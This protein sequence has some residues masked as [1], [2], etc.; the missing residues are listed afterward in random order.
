[1]TPELL[2]LRG[3]ACYRDETAIDF[4]GLDAPLFAIAGP[5]GS[6]K[7]V[8]LDAITFALYGQTARLGARGV[9]E[10][11]VSPGASTMTVQ[12][13]FST[14]GDRYRITRAVTVRASGA[15][16]EVRIEAEG[17]PGVWA[18]HAA[19]EKIR[20]AN[21]LLESIV[22]LDYDGFTR[23][24]LLPQGAFDEFLRGD[25]AK[26]RS[27]LTSL[28]NLDRLT[29]MQQEARRVATAAADRA[30]S[31]EARLTED[32]G[33]ATPEGVDRAREAHD[34]AVAVAA[35]ATAEAE[36][37]TAESARL[38]RLH[39]AHAQ[40]TAAQTLIDEITATL[41]DPPAERLDAMRRAEPLRGL[42]ATARA[43][44]ERATTASAR[45]SQARSTLPDL[46]ASAGFVAS[47]LVKARGALA[48]ATAER[49]AFLEV[50]PL[51]GRADAALVGHSG[52]GEPGA[53]GAAALAE[54]DAFREREAIAKTHATF[55]AAHSAAAERATKAWAA[56]RTAEDRLRDHEGAAPPS[57]DPSAK[58]D[59]VA[60]LE[61]ARRA[62]AAAHLAAH[63]H[64]G[65]PCPVCERPLEAPIRPRDSS[66]IEAAER[67]DAA[68][69]ALLAAER[70]IAQ[71][72]RDAVM[73]RE[74]HDAAVTAAL[75]AETA[76]TE[77]RQRAKDGG[78]DL[79]ADVNLTDW[80]GQ[81]AAILRRIRGWRDAQWSGHAVDE[82]RERLTDAVARESARVD[83][84][85]AQEREAREELASARATLTA[86]EEAE[87]IAQA[88]RQ[89]AKDALETASTFPTIDDAIAALAAPGE[90]DR[91]TAARAE[92]EARRSAAES[93]RDDA[94][95]ELGDHPFDPAERAR[96]ERD[97]ATAR[98]DAAR[99]ERA[100]G[101][102]AADLERITK[103]VERAAALTAERE[104]AKREEG[105]FNALSNELRGD[106]FPAFM[107]SKAQDQ[108][109][110]QAS[111][112]IRQITDDR[113][114]LVLSDGEFQV[115]DAWGTEEPRSARTLSGGETFIASLALA[116]ALSEIMVGSSE[117]GALFLDEGFGTLDAATLD[118]VATVLEHLTRDGRMVGLVTHVEALVERMPARL[119]V[120]KTPL[121][122]RVAWEA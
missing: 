85:E 75:E 74:R 26:R 89:E 121:G 86:A 104:G 109:A 14:G 73:Y 31:I 10:S 30:D 106:R 23:A 42:I 7:S 8:I 62:D 71:H 90:L 21:A 44:A 61:A 116:L 56:F 77:A 36:R 27:M 51:M 3:F 41:A 12:L 119:R 81:R 91:I 13:V 114:D 25:A 34:E 97:L 64:A 94:L 100:I 69:R 78:V 82:V 59:A 70:A 28:L 63:L 35:K 88:D 79:D 50:A 72:E 11:L 83:R 29:A 17:D 107:L 52:P 105:I 24:V 111:Y 43:A 93:R 49:E 122:S 53:D 95:A 60:A 67:A 65:D 80:M 113:Y 115:I 68:E 76:E 120:T 112:L 6:G 18:Q 118:S 20:D 5:T 55:A 19:S 87:S 96:V 4:R 102:A 117:L 40:A 33:D 32:F 38:D 57:A 15:A 110:A 37:L 46:H 58:A 98:A 103:A 2:T 22:G 47:D 39:G 9:L 99:A 101:T 108:L 1:M 84:L 66:V 16:Q 92:A 48:D 45:A 54:W